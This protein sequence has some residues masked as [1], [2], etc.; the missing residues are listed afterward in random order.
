MAEKLYRAQILLEQEQHKALSEI[1]TREGR[2]ISEVVREIIRCELERRECDA[3]ERRLRQ[4][5]TLERVRRHREEVLREWGGKPL[6]V[7]LVAELN[8]MRDERDARIMAGI[9]YDRD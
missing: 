3:E 1:A 2:S 5:E 8:E 6:E 7:D 9:I 4:R